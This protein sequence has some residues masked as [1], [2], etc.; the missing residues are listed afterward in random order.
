MAQCL[1]VGTEG[2]PVQTT[3]QAGVSGNSFASTL[4]ILVRMR[5]GPAALLNAVRSA[6]SHQGFRR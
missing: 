1:S 4:I 2:L 5:N 3:P 6:S